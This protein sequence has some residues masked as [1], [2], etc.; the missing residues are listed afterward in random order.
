MRV[1]FNVLN[2]DSRKGEVMKNSYPNNEGDFWCERFNEIQR[3]DRIL[4]DD[5]IY[6]ATRPHVMYKP[7]LFKDG[8]EWCALLGSNIQ[9][10]V[11]GF[12]KSPEKAFESFDKEFV[13]DCD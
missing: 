9:E 8:N 7:L 2:Y 6:Q 13:K 5:R 12:G 1:L 10:G 3:M 4:A 11:C